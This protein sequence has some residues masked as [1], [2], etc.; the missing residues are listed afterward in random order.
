M[1]DELSRP[2]KRHESASL[3]EVVE[4]VKAYAQQETIGPLKGI[5]RWIGVGA[6]GAVALG[7]GL[8]LVLL[9][10]LRLIQ[11]EWDGLADGGTSWIPYAIVLV[12]AVALLVLTLLR[13]NKTFLSKHDR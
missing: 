10:L 4:Y 2:S 6:G 3:G 7:L 1:A 9:G 8:S 5:G 11:S 13:I 12:V